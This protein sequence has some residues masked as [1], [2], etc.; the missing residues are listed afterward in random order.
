MKAE[1]ARF[2]AFG[3]NRVRAPSGALHDRLDLMC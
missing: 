2:V 3:L 1:S